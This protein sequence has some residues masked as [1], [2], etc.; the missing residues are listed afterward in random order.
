MAERVGFEP[1]LSV[2][3]K[4]LSDFQLPHEPLNTLQSPSRDT[5]GGRGAIYVKYMA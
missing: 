4:D 3:Y 5:C 2:E 1:L